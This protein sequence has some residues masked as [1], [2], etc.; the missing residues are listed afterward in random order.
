MHPTD[1]NLCVHLCSSQQILSRLISH[2]QLTKEKQFTS[3][4]SYSVLKRE[5]WPGNTM[6]SRLCRSWKCNDSERTI[7]PEQQHTYRFSDVFL[8][9]W[10]QKRSFFSVFFL[11]NYY[12][13]THWNDM[14][15]RTTVLTVEN[16]SF[17]NQG[18]YSASYVGD[19]PLRGAWM[20]LIVRGLLDVDIFKQQKHT[21]GYTIR[22][23]TFQMKMSQ[24]LSLE[25]C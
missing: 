4:C 16:A 7:H 3:A 5:M 11:G 23:R 15:N 18:V 14:V 20:R 1:G 13:M 25:M 8:T 24:V 17:V 22:V 6:V 21:E 19:S 12:Y 2:W 9:Q 10:G